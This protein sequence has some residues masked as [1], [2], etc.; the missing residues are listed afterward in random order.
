M[1]KEIHPEYRE[2][3]FTD[4]SADFRFI[5][6]STVDAKE[7]IEVDGKTYPHVPVDISAESHPFFTGKM[8]FVDTAG[9]VEKFQT[10][11]D[12]TM[13]RL[14]KEKEV[15]AEQDRL[16]KIAAAEAREAEK[17]AK[18]EAKAKAEEKRAK[19]KAAEERKAAKEAEKLAA[20][21]A[22][23]AEAEGTTATDSTDAVDSSSPTSSQNPEEEAAASEGTFAASEGSET[24]TEEVVPSAEASTETAE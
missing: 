3:V 5:T 8:K 10:K 4:A 2:V 20:A 9:R 24:E 17:A 23:K 13:K 16:D 11:F 14:K 1:K 15:A 12:K 21:Q 18:A 7:T 6:R 19:A 22:A